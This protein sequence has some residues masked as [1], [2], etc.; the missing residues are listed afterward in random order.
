MMRPL[1][2]YTSSRICV[3][4]SHPAHCSAGMMN[5]VQMSRSLRDCFAR[6]VTGVRSSVISLMHCPALHNIAF[7]NIDQQSSADASSDGR[8][9]GEVRR[10]ESA[11]FVD[12]VGPAD[13]R[14]GRCL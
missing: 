6:M 9:F 2:K 12:R 11:S 14:T 7:T 5:L 4:A 13:Q 8:E 10:K 3:I 1:V